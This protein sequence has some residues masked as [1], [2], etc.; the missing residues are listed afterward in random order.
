MM[1]QFGNTFQFWSIAGKIDKIEKYRKKGIQ[2]N[3]VRSGLTDLKEENKNLD[4]DE[5][6]TDKPNEIAN[7]VKMI[8]EFNNQNQEEK[9]LKIV[10]LDQ[11]LSRLPI[12]LSLLKAGDNS[13]KT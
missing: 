7:L 4:E 6:E 1:N 10:T 5:K 11:T 2:L 12:S 13:E 3:L 9:G 8:L